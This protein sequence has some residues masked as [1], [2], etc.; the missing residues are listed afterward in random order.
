[1]TRDAVIEEATFGGL[2]RAASPDLAFGVRVAASVSLALFAAFWRE[3]DNAF[4]AAASAAVVCQPNLGASLRKA[5][6]RLIG[7]LVGAAM[8]VAIAA[9]FTQDRV[10]FLAALALWGAACALLSTLL[11][12]F[13]SYGA[14]LAGYT[15]AIVARDALGASGGGPDDHVFILALWRASEICTGIVCAGLVFALTD[16][17][18]ARSRVA[19]MVSTLVGRIGSQFVSTLTTL[20]DSRLIRREFIRD[21]IALDP[22]LD[23]AIGESFELRYDSPTLAQTADGLFSALAAWRAVDNHLDRASADLSMIQEVQSVLQALPS[24]ARQAWDAAGSGCPI[25]DPSALRDCCLL[26]IR[27]LLS[28]PAITASRQLLIDQT[29][30]ALFGLSEALTGLALLAGEPNLRP[31]RSSRHRVHVA[32]WAP[33]VLNAARASLAICAAAMVWIVT[34]WSEGALCMTWT[35]ITVILFGPRGENASAS[36]VTFLAGTGIA[37]I[38]AAIA[39]FAIL[40]QVHSFTALAFVLSCYMIPVGALSSRYPNSAFLM[41]MAANFVPLVAPANLATYDTIAFY[42]SALAL[43]TGCAIGVLSFQLLAPLSPATRTQR[44]LRSTLR[45]L[46]RMAQRPLPQLPDD[47]RGLACAR[48]TDLPDSAEPLQ[49]ARI[50]AALSAGTEMIRLDRLMRRL[51][52]S[53]SLTPVLAALAQ[54][55]SGPASVKLAYLATALSAKACASGLRHLGLHARA[56]ALALSEVLTQHSPYFDAGLHEAL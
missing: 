9:L 35:A 7:T 50:V 38:L 4:W 5:W 24:T 45:D 18:H 46:R 13:A 48:L 8:I 20:K 16:L 39:N 12:N 29:A 23:Q 26:A 32:D 36:A 33:P 14:A 1:M 55:R 3:L 25:H 52:L 49:R 47:W 53:S 6:F 54:G 43:C 40:P 27:R 2:L 11:R 41:A 15:A 34:S 51:S 44:M 19:Q 30:R 21:V 31:S 10:G 22:A 37:A 42:N 28:R 17:G 56:S